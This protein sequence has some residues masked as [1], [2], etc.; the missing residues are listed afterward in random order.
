MFTVPR[1]H[2]SILHKEYFRRW[3]YVTEMERIG[4]DFNI[5]EKEK[6]VLFEY[7]KNLSVDDKYFDFQMKRFMA[8][9]YCIE[10]IKYDLTL[11][12]EYAREMM[13]K[14][15]EFYTSAGKEDLIVRVDKCIEFLENRR[16]LIN[17]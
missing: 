15:Y 13:E 10:S 1:K 16:G 5:L 11:V 3:L 6:F 9:G 12:C 17:I 14:L 4:C 2:Q 7:W 8:I